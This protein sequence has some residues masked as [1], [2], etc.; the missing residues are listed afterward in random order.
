MT[1][2]EQLS[3]IKTTQAASDLP[4]LDLE[5]TGQIRVYPRSVQHVDG[6]SLFMGRE[7]DGKSLFLFYRDMGS[8]YAGLFHAESTK[9]IETGILSRCPLTHQNADAVRQMLDFTRPILIGLDT[10]IGLGDRLGLA[11]PGHLQAVEG[12]DIRPVL[13]QQSIR[14]LERTERTPEEVMDAATWAVLQEGYEGGFGSDADHLKTPEHIDLMMQAGFT[15]FTIDPGDHVVNEADS[16]PVGELD[17]TG[18]A[19]DVLED[20]PEHFISRYADRKLP[21]SAR[22]TLEPTEEDVLRALV[23][24]GNVLIHTV[25][26]AGYLH[27]RYPDSPTELELS[28]DETESVTSPFEHF[29][30]VNELK[31]LGIELVSLAPRFVGDFEKGIDYKGDLE[32]FKEEFLK[33]VDIAEHLGPYKISFHSGSDKF[34][35]YELVGSLGE[36][37]I[38]V[39]TAGTS[40]LEA[41]R[42]VALVDPQF[43]REI[44]D[45][46]RGLYDT[47]KRTYH[48]SAEPGKVRPSDGYA[49]EELTELFDQDD[50]RQVLHVT[51]GRVLTEKDPAG[52]YIFRER[53]AALLQHHEEEH[54]DILRRHFRRHIEPFIH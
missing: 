24:Y 11:N 40:Y 4:V 28:V 25:K 13:A 1:I 19:W 41:L 17:V 32:L 51:F 50:A 6:M 43:F 30:V 45:F 16:L 7:G 21:V 34:Q 12:T 26:M 27:E 9:E 37:R 54:Y 33:H 5:T 31:R 46:S 49:D 23:K 14:E 2:D 52:N 18:L 48:V 29:M 22:L 36:G 53:L 10:S 20:T 35:V 42:T 47:E 38:H 39:K 8:H 15:M 44:L 3:S